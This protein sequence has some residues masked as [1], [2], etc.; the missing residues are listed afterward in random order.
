MSNNNEIERIIIR[1]ISGSKANQVEQIPFEGLTELTIGRD[2]SSKIMFDS[3]RDDIA[4]R[5][6]AVIRVMRGDKNSFRL[7][8]LGSSN[9]TFLNG[10]RITEEKELLPEDSIELGKNG[11]KFVFDVQPRPPYLVSRTRTIAVN[12]P[13]ATRLVKAAEVAV[14]VTSI[15][16]ADGNGDIKVDSSIQK[17]EPP[18]KPGVGKETVMRLLGEERRATS[19]VWISSLAGV[20][21]V[22]ALAGGAFY[23]KH[24]RDLKNE[25]ALLVSKI[26]QNAD[27]IEEKNQEEQRRQ[28][29]ARGLSS[30]EV[31]TLFGNAT[32]QIN[33]SWRLYDKATGDPVFQLT[34]GGVVGEGGHRQIKI[35]PAYVRL[36]G[37]GPIVRWLTLEHDNRSNIEIGGSG[38]GTGFVVDEQGFMLT[39]KHVAA[40]W[41]LSFGQ[42][43]PANGYGYGWLFEEADYFDTKKKHH[44]PPTLIDL[45]ND[46]N[47]FLRGWVPA[48]GGVVFDRNVPIPI[49]G[50]IPDPSKNT[51]RTFFGRNDSLEVRFAN[52]RGKASATL[53]RFSDESDAALIKVDTPQKLKALNIANDD[54]IG[55]GEPVIAIGFPGVAEPI[56]AVSTTIENGQRRDINDIIP[57]PFVTEG[58]VSLISPAVRTV[59]EVTFGGARGDVFQMSINSTGAGN[60]GGPVFNKKGQVIGIFTYTSSLGGAN[61]TEAI[62]IKYGRNLL[63]SQ[64]P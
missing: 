7:A 42:A 35:F 5:R 28:A 41:N 40:P 49:G 20:A 30:Q 51:E 17:F 10:E 46:Q 62:P 43:D 12:D 58:I 26:D 63:L 52:S 50:N 29:E 55:T 6:H 2:P 54:T 3:P 34:F 14:A 15:Q 48:S 64:A 27:V 19:R 31:V 24:Q 53:V 60:S 56:L 16:E 22:V 32:A 9:G 59:N 1:H 33:R 21:A 39:N 11:L 23:W 25:E 61:T 38:S 47:A 18:L 44:K 4:S 36:A 13:A 45:T 57:V 8:D 37:N